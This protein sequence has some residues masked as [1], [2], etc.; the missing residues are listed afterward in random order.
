VVVCRLLNASWGPELVRD[1]LSGMVGRK[2]AMK[3]Y[4]GGNEREEAA[5]WRS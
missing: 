3:R 1:G 2:G 5:W 4:G